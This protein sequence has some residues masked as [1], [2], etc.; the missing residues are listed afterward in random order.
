MTVTPI[1][2]HDKE[3][4]RKMHGYDQKDVDTFLDDVIVSYSDALDRIVELED[5]QAKMQA[6]IDEYDSLKEK[7]N[8]SIIMAQKAADEIRED[9]R[10]EADKMLDEA[11]VTYKTE[12]ELAEYT[13][14][15][16]ELKKSVTE[17]QVYY[18]RLKARVGKFRSKTQSLL[19]EEANHLD[20]EGWQFWLD[21]YYD[22]ND[23]YADNGDAVEPGQMLN[24]DS[25]RIEPLDSSTTSDVEFNHEV[26]NQNEHPVQV[27]PTMVDDGLPNSAGPVIV[28]PDDYK[29]H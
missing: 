29:N 22:A 2:I 8:E 9:A 14:Q 17:L 7:I 15:L 21:R 28:F 3:F 18:E 6:Q 27:D 25:E 23:F 11:N 1:E 5:T 4:K 20:D 12:H 24:N 19:R 16:A 26:V 13:A 10:A